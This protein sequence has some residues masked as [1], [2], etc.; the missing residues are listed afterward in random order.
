MA[1]LEIR[2]LHVRAAD[3]DILKGLDLTAS[4][5]E[6]HALMGP[7]GSGKS[8]LANVIMGQPNLEVT[9][10]QII[11][12]GQDITEADPD[13]R[14][15]MG[16]FM[17]FQYPVSIPGVTITKYLRMVMNAH[18][19]ER[20]EG[21]VSLKDFRKLV[22]QAMELTHV[23][24]E[25]SSRYLNEGFSGGEKKR[26]EILQLALQR[27]EIAVL[28]ETD[29]GLD[30]DALNTVAHGVNTVAARDRPRRAHHHPLP[31]HPAPGQA[32][33]R[34]DH[35]R[36]ADRQAGRLG[37]R[38]A[39]RAR[40]VW[41]GAR[42]GRGG[43]VAMGALA[44]T[45]IAHEFPSLDR[46]GLVYLDTGA[47]S[48]TPRTVLDAMEDYYAHHRA[49]VHRGVYP[50]AVEATELF[51]GARERIARWLN[52]GVE[53]T[54]FTGNVTEALNL[55]AYAWG[56]ANVGPGDRVV[57]TEMEHHSNFVPWQQLALRRGAEFSVVGFD[58]EGQLDLD[59]LDALLAGGDVKVVAVVHVSNTLG[60]INPVQEIVR[61]AHD[62]GAIVVVDGAQ[63]VPQM[64]VDLAALGADFYGW[65]GHKAYGPTGVGVLHGRAALLDE[66]PPFITG[67]HMI[68]SVSTEETRWAQSPA[69]FEAG[70]SN[71]AEA[72]GLGAA[73]DFLQ[74]IGMEH[75][76][77]H[78]REL[79]AYALERLGAIEGITLHGPPDAAQRGALVSFAIDGV[80]P[81]D[82]AE[83]LG[84]QGICV[85][86]GH[87]CTQP[88]MRRLGVG[89]TSRA[90][91]G[92][93]NT[94]EDVDALITGL[95]AV[96]EVF[97]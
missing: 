65:T 39:A 12:K 96:K 2:N 57:V 27:P 88:L 86:A 15:R 85:R 81:H 46:E 14:A 91:F 7:N 38:R 92:V 1:D 13:E 19:H 59:A 94:H 31:A 50:L 93:H 64:P 69:K 76:R 20:G 89:A 41:L 32:R 10:G 48:Q 82:V 63:A 70:T 95:A 33:P 54:I 22:E 79:V 36:G 25:F 80:H 17:A 28:D 58:E 78:E 24:R 97:A 90:S 55:V 77:D 56:D 49:S 47:T 3:K 73:V 61:R 68:A 83:I 16:L 51:E 26:L 21:E 18:R 9:E 75:V 5:G 43:G 34:V 11:F 71:I 53:E 52:W 40:G 62:A 8:T 30:I 67:G 87:H 35:V 66:M 42:R 4:K 72:I 6:V 44:D 60:T 37:A 29:S 23:P 84:R 74:G 45:A